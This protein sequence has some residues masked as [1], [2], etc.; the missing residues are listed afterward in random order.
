MN[1]NLLGE[2]KNC[3]LP[4]VKVNLPILTEKDIDDLVNFGCKHEV[5]FV[6]ASFVQVREGAT[7]KVGYS[8][9]FSS[10]LTK[11]VNIQLIVSI[12]LLECG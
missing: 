5:D 6:A 1:A 3:N 7:L 9:D 4:G 11:H 10:A 2:R 8:I 12:H